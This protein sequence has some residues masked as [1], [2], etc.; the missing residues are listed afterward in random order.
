M[1]HVSGQGFTDASTT[2]DSRATARNTSAAGKGRRSGLARGQSLAKIY[3]IKTNERVHE[4]VA[5]LPLS[6]L[7]FANPQDY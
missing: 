6:F 7:L 1:S 4:N 5:F 2:S 3:G